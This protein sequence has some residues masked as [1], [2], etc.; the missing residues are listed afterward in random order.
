MACCHWRVGRQL[1][2]PYSD[3]R[4]TFRREAIL[5]PAEPG[6]RLLGAAADPVGRRPGAAG[7]PERLRAAVAALV[8]YLPAGGATPE[9][10]RPAYPDRRYRRSQPETDRPMAVAARDHG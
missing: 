7:D 5:F 1:Q 6:H 9:R 8:R 3:N 2:A 10:E 4:C